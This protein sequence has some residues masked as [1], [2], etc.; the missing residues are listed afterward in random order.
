VENIKLLKE[1]NMIDNKVLRIRI[2]IAI[3]TFII[4]CGTLI[5]FFKGWSPWF[6]GQNNNISL[7]L[8]FLSFAMLANGVSYLAEIFKKK[9]NCLK[10]LTGILSFVIFVFVLFPQDQDTRPIIGWTILIGL[11]LS[12]I[13]ISVFSLFEFTHEFAIMKVYSFVFAIFSGIYSWIILSYVSRGFGN[14]EAG[15]GYMIY[16]LIMFLL[17][18]I[19][20]FF[21]ISSLNNGS[22]GN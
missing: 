16:G 1:L 11:S 3:A 10:T 13:L 15:I 8:V 12:S 21:S 19:V 4:L 22:R 5:P 6:P 2:I 20:N 17:S 9:K 7:L 18:M 14:S